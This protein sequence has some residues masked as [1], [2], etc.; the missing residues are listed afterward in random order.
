MKKRISFY[1]LLKAQIILSNLVHSLKRKRKHCTCTY[2]TSERA[3]ACETAIVWSIQIPYTSILSSTGRQAAWVY[4]LVEKEPCTHLMLELHTCIH[5]CFGTF[6]SQP[7]ASYSDLMMIDPCYF[8]L[9]ELVMW[10]RSSFIPKSS[11]EWSSETRLHLLQSGQRQTSSTAM[12]KKSFFF[13]FY[14]CHRSFSSNRL[15]RQDFS[16]LLAPT[17][18]HIFPLNN[19]V[20]F[21]GE[22][23][24]NQSLDLNHCHISH[25][26]FFIHYLSM[27]RKAWC[28][29]TC[30]APISFARSWWAWANHSPLSALSWFCTCP[31]YC[32]PWCHP[33][34]TYLP[35]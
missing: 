31:W 10:N 33:S 18:S 3:T 34:L 32:W 27:G 6:S 8:S 26:S 30:T 14:I 17:L 19:N 28:L 1:S 29:E 12:W 21:L 9:F 5:F 4:I 13:A 15:S 24:D 2:L 20:I 23:Y 35:P 16:L 7:S 11:Q 25:L 22:I